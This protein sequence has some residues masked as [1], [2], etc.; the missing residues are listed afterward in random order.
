MKLRY[1]PEAI[2]DLREIGRYIKSVL[3]NP[4][5]AA[6]VTRA[7]LDACASLKSFP[8]MGVS[9]ESKTG[10][11]TD[12]R[13]LPCRGW[14]AAYRVDPE[15]GVVSVARIINARQDYMRV[16]FGEMDS[17]SNLDLP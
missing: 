4:I 2:A 7:I 8:E 12:L 9:V 11:E 5:A 6:N 17:D 10:F 16:L 1:T 3:R 15:A 13:I 14:L